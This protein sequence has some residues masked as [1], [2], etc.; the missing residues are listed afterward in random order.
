MQTSTVR[1]ILILA[2][3]TGSAG[4]YAADKLTM[5]I[6]NQPITMYRTSDL[7]AAKQEAAAAHKPI[8]WIA[9]SPTLLDGRGSITQTN[10]RGATLHALLAVHEKTVIIFED[11][12]EENHKVL[13][14]VD[15][16]LHTPNPHY[17][18]PTVLFLDPQLTNVLATVIYEPNF[19]QRAAALAKA[20]EDVKGKF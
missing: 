15:H 13:K 17:V 16:A 6:N 3:A 11:A 18:P 4:A 1:L 2:L 14:L 5:R 9:S 7:D 8:A 10:S 19:K 12:Y 20:L